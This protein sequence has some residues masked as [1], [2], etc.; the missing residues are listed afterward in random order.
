MEQRL[1]SNPRLLGD[2]IAF[3]DLDTFGHVKQAST[4]WS[5]ALWRAGTKAITW[6]SRW[7][8]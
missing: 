3:T 5:N 7:L 1:L 2:I 6:P 8:D 4:R